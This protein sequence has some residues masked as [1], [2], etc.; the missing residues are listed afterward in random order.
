MKTDLVNK[1]KRNGLDEFVN[2]K[3]FTKDISLDMSSADVCLI[4]SLMKDPFPTT[5][6]EAMSAGKAIIATD[7]GGAKEAIINNETGLVVPPNQPLLLAGAIR[8]LIKDRAL[9]NRMGEKA[10]QSFHENF[11]INH[12]NARWRSAV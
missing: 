3:G 9:V 1:I 8:K 6:L 4:P 11:T 5:V 10:K 7:T 12:F 2:L